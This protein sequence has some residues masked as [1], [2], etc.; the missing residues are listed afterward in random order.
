MYEINEITVVSGLNL[1]R[2]TL[3]FRTCSIMALPNYLSVLVALRH[4]CP[5]TI[6]FSMLYYLSIHTNLLRRILVVF[7]NVSCKYYI[8]QAFFFIMFNIFHLSHSDCNYKWNMSLHS[9]N[10][11]KTCLSFISKKQPNIWKKDLIISMK[12]IFC[13]FSIIIRNNH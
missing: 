2:H 11:S 10:L 8:L 4:F 5:F 6:P 3:L 13:L 9:W 12:F 7:P 1:Q